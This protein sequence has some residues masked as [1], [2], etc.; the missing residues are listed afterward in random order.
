[1]L[2][3]SNDLIEQI[4]AHLEEAYPDEGAGFLLGEEGQVV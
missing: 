3:V 1:M 4:N 2:A